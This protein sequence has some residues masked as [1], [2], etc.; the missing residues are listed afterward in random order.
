MLFRFPKTFK[1]MTDEFENEHMET[2]KN[3]KNKQQELS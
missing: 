2:E 1:L 3:A